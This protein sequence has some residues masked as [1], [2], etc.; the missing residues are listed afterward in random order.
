MPGDGQTPRGPPLR[1][2][3]TAP[4]KRRG[5]AVG[6]LSRVRRER[7]ALRF[8]ELVRIGLLGGGNGARGLPLPPSTCAASEKGEHA[9]PEDI[10]TVLH[11]DRRAADGEHGRAGEVQ[12]VPRR[13]HRE[14][15]RQGA[16]AAVLARRA[17]F[18]IALKQPVKASCQARRLDAHP[19]ER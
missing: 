19:T 11:A 3:A 16:D 14:V 4:A 15:F 2:P 12:C 7:A 6:R 8:L 1:T 5:R 13:A 10:E 18:L 9:D 17:C